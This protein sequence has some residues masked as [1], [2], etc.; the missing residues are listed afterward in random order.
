MQAITN[1]TDITIINFV[2]ETQPSDKGQND[3]VR[4]VS[5]FIIFLLYAMLCF[6]M[7]SFDEY[8]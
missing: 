1:G 5:L 3:R 4:F 2:L 7:C 8:E 6:R